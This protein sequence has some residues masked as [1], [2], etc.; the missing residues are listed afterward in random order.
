MLWGYTNQTNNNANT[1]SNTEIYIPNYT[2]SNYKSVSSDSVQEA[3][4]T[5]NNNMWLLAGLWSNT[6]AITQIDIGADDTS[7]SYNF[8]QYSTFTLYGIKNS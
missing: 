6:G 4:D 8:L 1:F 5:T 3:N 2:S 7:S